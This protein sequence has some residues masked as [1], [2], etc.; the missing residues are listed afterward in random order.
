ML[1]LAAMFMCTVY[2]T[3]S[4]QVTIGSGRAPSEW[5]LLDLCTR[6]QQRALH[7]ARMNTEQR[8]S[9]M[10]EDW[11][12]EAE[13]I[14]A[15]G[16]LIF[17]TDPPGCLE[18]WSGTRWVSLCVGDEICEPFTDIIYSPAR[19]FDM[20]HGNSVRLSVTPVGG[21]APYS[22]QWFSNTTNSTGGT[23]IEDATHYY[24][25]YDD[26]PVG[27]HYFYV[28]ITKDCFGRNIVTS[29]IFEVNV[30][31]ASTIIAIPLGTGGRLVGRTCFDI[32]ETTSQQLTPESRA[33]RRTDFTDREVTD[34]L[35]FTTVSSGVQTYRFTAAAGS[36]ISNVRYIIQ[37]PDGI[38][39][40]AYTPLAGTLHS[41][42]LTSG[43]S[44]DLIVHFR[45]DLNTALQGRN[46]RESARAIIHIIWTETAW[47]ERRVS[48]NIR[49]RD[50]YCCGA[51][52]GQFDAWRE[53]MCHNVGA[54][55]NLNPFIPNQGLHGSMFR[56]GLRNPTLNTNN[57]IN[58]PGAI[59][60]WRDTPVHNLT[61]GATWS[62]INFGLLNPCPTGFRVPN[63]SELTF[64]TFSPANWNPRTWVG[65]ATDG[66]LSGVM[67]ESLF[68]PATGWRRNNDGAIE[69]RG[70]SVRLWSSQTNAN[71]FGRYVWFLSTIANAG[72][73]AAW[74]RHQAMPVRCITQ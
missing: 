56:W 54:D 9:L 2:S 7:N 1:F 61:H 60:G 36:N 8:D 33:P 48:L 39:D 29:E 13:R 38:I 65:P 10:N 11:L 71:L 37:D 6:E 64:L 62:E 66:F 21:S 23:P 47:E 17:N 19:V 40:Q 63:E 41:G 20:I 53:F 42:A 18:F 28:V 34:H 5:S 51:I 31:N 59:A 3:V 27:I 4:A 50:S 73:S 46:A 35:N 44:V 58:M 24:L 25:T 12:P 32:A 16:L 43:L 67:M 26:L 72:I 30:V 22:F 55:E 49:V 74:D 52:V 68:L 15:Q 14:E 45:Y 57:N 70:T 69:Y